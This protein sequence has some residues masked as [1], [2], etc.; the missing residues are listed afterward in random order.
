MLLW[1]L[2][3]ML[4]F[5]ISIFVCL[6]LD[7]YSGVELLSHMVV[8]VLVLGEISMPFSTMAAL[9][10][11][12]TNNVQGAPF[13]PHLCHHL[14]L[15]FFL[16][17][18]ML[19]AVRWYLIVVLICIFLMI[20]D[21]KH[22]FL[23]LLIICISSLAKCLFRSVHL[24]LSCVFIWCLVVWAVYMCWI[25][26]PYQSYISKYFLPF[27]RLPFYFVNGFLCYAE[28]FKFN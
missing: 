24:Q 13:F 11:I 3:C 22:L 25:L 8:L 26:I 27:S 6:F 4:S 17:I 2:R 7:I 5:Q 1:T 14:L 19:I 9:I 23:Y 18:A 15:V 10:Y 28:S 16:M 21:V 12:S 20:S